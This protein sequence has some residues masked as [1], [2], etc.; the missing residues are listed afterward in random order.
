MIEI[1]STCIIHKEE[2]DGA[3]KG[4]HNSDSSADAERDHSVFE[5]HRRAHGGVLAA[6]DLGD[7]AGIGVFSAARGRSKH[8][9]YLIHSTVLVRAGA[10]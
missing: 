2:I 1:L 6:S 3:A 4:E 7:R 9:A 5:A 10:G 8:R